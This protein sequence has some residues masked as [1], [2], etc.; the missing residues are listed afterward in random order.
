[1]LRDPLVRAVRREARRLMAAGRGSHGFDH[2]ERVLALA[3]RLGAESGADERV[4]ALAA[5]L[6]DVGR[7]QEDGSA[8]ATCHA[9]AGAAMAREILLRHGADARCAR[10]VADC[11]RRHRYRGAARPASREAKLLFDA[12]KLDSLGAVGIGRAFLFAGEVGARLHNSRP[13]PAGRRTTVPA[14]PPTASGWS[15]CA[16]CRPPADGGGQAPG[17]RSRGVRGGVFRAAR[18]GGRGKAMSAHALRASSP[19]PAP[20]WRSPPARRA[21]RRKTPAE[22]RDVLS[23]QQRLSSVGAEF[24]L[25]WDAE[26]LDALR[27]TG[28]DIAL[29]IGAPVDSY[30]YYV[31]DKPILNAFT[32]PTGDIFFF[33]GQLAAMRSSS[34]LAGVLAHEIAHVQAGHY[35]RLSRSSSLG[36]IPAIAAII[37]SGGNPAVFAGALA[38]LES[39][40][41]AFSREMEEE[42][43]RL[44]MIYLRR[45]SYDPRGL[46]GAMRLIEAGE[47]FMPSYAPES[48][49]T[50]P[51]TA[52]RIGALENGLGL[53]PGRSTGPAPTPAGTGSARYCSPW[54]SRSGR[55]ASSAS[56]PARAPRSTS[57]CSGSSTRAAATPPR[58]PRTSDWPSP[59]RPGRPVTRS[60]WAWRSGRSGTPPARAPK[61]SGR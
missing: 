23:R 7:A 31:I 44:S 61:S 36:T 11:V 54:T 20:C 57:T 26:V 56:G 15:S 22:E 6:H 1:M 47:R 19:S 33:T 17:R 9:A 59:R 45:T 46:L 2:V 41:L 25:L 42:A 28:G 3:L 24:P 4:L 18:R 5:L 60:T 35:E 21:R 55:C 16:T 32:S 37:L 27:R 49:R 53:P 40:Q 29:A 51:L 8:G 34:E 39:Y 48:L 30:H 52:S 12:D 38:L 43:D 50:H 14:T 58:P 10:R 13:P